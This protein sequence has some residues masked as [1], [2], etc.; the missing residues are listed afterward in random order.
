MSPTIVG[1]T[2]V[3]L[4]IYEE[5]PAAKG[6]LLHQFTDAR[7]RE[8]LSP[9]STD[10]AKEIARRDVNREETSPGTVARTFLRLSALR[11]EIA[12]QI[13][14]TLKVAASKPYGKNRS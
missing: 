8:Q 11:N 2:R 5:K 1:T 12:Q 4:A 10:Q 14:E 9:R 3:T 13:I 7:A 6:V